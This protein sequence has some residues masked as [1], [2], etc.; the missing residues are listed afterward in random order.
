MLTDAH[1]HPYDLADFLPNYGNEIKS[2]NIIAAASACTNDEFIFNEKLSHNKENENK[3]VILPC[4]GIHPQLLKVWNQ[5]R[6]IKTVIETECEKLLVQMNNL[7]ETGRIAAIGECG[8]DLFNDSF[9]ETEAVQDRLFTEHLETALLY[10]LPVVLHVRRAMHKI[11]AEIKKLSKCKAVI[12]HSWS[13]TYEEGISLLRRGV[14]TYFSFGN[15]IML[16]HK[17]AIRSCALFPQDRLLTETDAPFQPRRG[18]KYSKWEDLPLILEAASIIRNEAG[19]KI[20]VNELEVQTEI[21]FR[22]IFY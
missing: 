18:E 15:T 8:F 2:S 1:C 14:N 4:F 9:R 6:L 13:G 17:Q 20:D 11:F 19:N 5:N 3:T 21:N 16:N 10:D 12:F 7:A 22:K